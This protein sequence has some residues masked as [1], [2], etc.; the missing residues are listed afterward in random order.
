MHART[1]AMVCS[2]PSYG[3]AC[4]RVCRVIALRVACAYRTVSDIALSVVAGLPPLYLMACERAEVYREGV[5]RE[6]GHFDQEP[7]RIQLGGGPAIEHQQGVL[8]GIARNG[9]VLHNILYA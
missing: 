7:R 3:T 2:N 9:R 8:V 6:E 4:R 5:I 1:H